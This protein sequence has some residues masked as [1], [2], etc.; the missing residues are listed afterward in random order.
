M[1][2]LV[3]SVYEYKLRMYVHVQLRTCICVQYPVHGY[4][5]TYFVLVHTIHL[6]VFPLDSAMVLK[7]RSDE[8]DYAMGFS[9]LISLARLRGCTPG[10][11]RKRQTTYTPEPFEFDNVEV[12]ITPLCETRVCVSQHHIQSTQT[13]YAQALTCTISAI[14]MLRIF[15]YCVLYYLA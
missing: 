9:G 2:Q 11:R 15:M 10:E 14:C 12:P 1:S 3:C 7:F 6:Y 8:R 4:T 5:H 13:S